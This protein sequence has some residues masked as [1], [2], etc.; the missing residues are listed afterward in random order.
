VIVDTS[1]VVAIARMEPD[2]PRYVEAMRD[3]RPQI[4]AATVLE[5]AL[6]LRPELSDLLDELLSEAGVTIV[7]FDAHQLAA[8]RVG[9]A[10]YGRGSGS[11]A[12]LN[13]G[14]CFSYAL[15]KTAGS[16]LLFKGDDFTHTDIEPALRAD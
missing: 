7:P 1:A 5:C 3:A 11:P 8:A 9:M 16:P 14:D 10:R 4:S 2:G 6:V 13:Y 15:A 12:R